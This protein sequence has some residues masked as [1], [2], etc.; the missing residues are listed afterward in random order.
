MKISQNLSITVSLR[1]VQ[2]EYHEPISRFDVQDV[3]LIDV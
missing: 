2:E 3:L 1:F